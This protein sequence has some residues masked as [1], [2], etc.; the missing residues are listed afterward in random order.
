[1]LLNFKLLDMKGELNQAD[2]RFL[3]TGG[4]SLGEELPECPAFWMSNQAW[5]E[6]IRAC[7]LPSF[8]QTPWLHEAL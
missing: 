4:V 8:Q 3:I 1:M 5:G 7:K 6:M 2:L